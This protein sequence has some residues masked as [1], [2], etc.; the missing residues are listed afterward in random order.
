MDRVQ[1]VVNLAESSYVNIEN[2]LSIFWIEKENASI[3]GFPSGADSIK[4]KSIARSPQPEGSDRD[5]DNIPSVVSKIDHDVRSRR[6]KLA[7][8]TACGFPS[9][10]ESG[11]PARAPGFPERSRTSF[12]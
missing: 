11:A 2:L 3:I 5:L 9:A 10:T 7:L 1:A 8:H 4:S 12:I 6:R